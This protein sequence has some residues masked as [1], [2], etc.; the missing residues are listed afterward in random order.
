[1]EGEQVFPRCAPLNAEE[2][3]EVAVGLPDAV[4]FV[5]SILQV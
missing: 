5:N 3:V 2:I 1:M 4:L